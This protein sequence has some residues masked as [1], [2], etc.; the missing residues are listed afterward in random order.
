MN[1]FQTVPC[2]SLLAL[3]AA[4]C[5][6]GATYRDVRLE[7]K[8]IRM[9]LVERARVTHQLNWPDSTSELLIEEIQGQGRTSQELLRLNHIFPDVES[10]SLV[11]ALNP[12]MRSLSNIGDERLRIPTL[13]GSPELRRELA[14]G[15]IVLLTIDWK[16][17]Q[18]FKERVRTLNR[19]ILRMSGAQP[20]PL[21]DVPDKQSDF[22][23]LKLVSDRLTKIDERIQQRYGRAVPTEVVMQLSDETELLNQV[24]AANSDQGIGSAEK[25]SIDAVQKDV[26]LKTKAFTEVAAGEAPS[27][28][29]EAD[30]LVKTLKDGREIP[31]LR[32]YYIPEALC[33]GES[34]AERS[35]CDLKVD[36]SRGFNLLTLPHRQKLPEADYC[37]WASQDPSHQRVTNVH[38]AEVRATQPVE[39]ELTVGAK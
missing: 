2:I 37:F 32:I 35:E 12:D 13:R 5:C 19:L 39:I 26:L 30:V 4:R 1:N 34:R 25:A 22:A 20:A 11:Y 21:Q 18:Q 23:S 14:A 10:F 33:D 8:D 38:C 31:Y 6:S 3:L 36:E 24:L 15:Y 17:K 27:R 9:T 28:W 7:G 16:Y 29:P